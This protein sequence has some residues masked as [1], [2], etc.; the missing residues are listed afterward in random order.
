MNSCVDQTNERN[1]RPHGAILD[2]ALAKVWRF[3][4]LGETSVVSEPSN[5][6][7]EEFLVRKEGLL[8]VANENRSERHPRLYK[9]RG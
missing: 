7:L 5:N 1:L 8:R 6:Y 3:R 4:D 2:C 9:S